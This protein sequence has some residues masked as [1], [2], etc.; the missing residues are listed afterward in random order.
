MRSPRGNASPF[1]KDLVYPAI[2]YSYQ[3]GRFFHSWH[4]QRLGGAVAGYSRGNET[5]FSRPAS[6]RQHH[7]A[8]VTMFI[9]Y[10]DTVPS[11]QQ[12]CSRN[13]ALL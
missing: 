13:Q 2:A 11:P 5:R 12:H 10:E 3:G 7:R 9:L 4:W 8:H 1:N 6:C